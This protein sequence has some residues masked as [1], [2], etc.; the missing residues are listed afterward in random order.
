MVGALA[1]GCDRSGTVT[2][3]GSDADGGAGATAGD[4]GHRGDGGPEPPGGAR[5]YPCGV[6]RTGPSLH[7][8]PDGDDSGPCT[9]AAPCR[10]LQRAA[11]AA[12]E[13]G[14]VVR[15]AAGTYQ[16]FETVHPDV[17]F[18]AIG[19]VV[20]DGP[21]AGL[22]DNIRVAGTDRVVIAGFRVRG[23]ARAGISVLDAE[24]VVVCDNVSGPNGR[25]GIFTQ[26]APGVV[27]AA[28]QAFGS[29]S[30]HGIYL[31]NSY[32]AGDAPLVQGNLVHDNRLSGIQLNGDCMWDGDGSLEDAVIEG[33]VVHD[34]GAKG[35]SVI[36]APGVLIANNIIHHN[37][38]A[39]GGIHMTN[40][41]GCPAEDASSGGLVVNNTVVEPD[42]AAFRATD[43]ATGNVVFNNLFVSPTGVLDQVGGNHRSDNLVVDSA[44]GLFGPGYTLAPGSAAR[45]SGVAS[46]MGKG[47]PTHAIDG[48]TRPQGAA[49]DLGAHEATR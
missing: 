3:S 31:S 46:F 18:V 1:L 4:A 39:A 23:A 29:L 37:G 15:V 10:T 8:A 43:D 25:W 17:S 34:N 47:A 26:Y 24:D 6:A 2:G 36:A 42:I 11:E 7:V 20:I 33:N 16:G 27:I 48:T 12:G 49:I 41:P 45:D 35:L 44:E 5:A 28:N 13:A 32:V 9:Q 14:S 22:D 40:E 30:E 38:P 19:Q 21:H